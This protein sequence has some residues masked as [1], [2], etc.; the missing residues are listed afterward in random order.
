MRKI[1]FLRYW[2]SGIFLILAISASCAAQQGAE[3]D[4]I[5]GLW[6]TDEKDAHVE[7]FKCEGAYCGKIVWLKEPEIDGKPVL[8]EKNGHECRHGEKLQGLKRHRRQKVAD[9][10]AEVHSLRH[11]AVHPF[12]NIGYEDDDAKKGKSGQERADELSQYIFGEDGH[13]FSI[14]LTK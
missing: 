10:V 8:D 7:I 3:A 9:H 11:E 6:L 2:V 13:L 4:A 12:E 5:L 14:L 1:S